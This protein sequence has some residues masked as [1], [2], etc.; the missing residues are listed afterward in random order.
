MAHRSYGV[1]RAT[2]M[3]F[4]RTCC[5]TSDQYWLD[6]DRSRGPPWS[7]SDFSLLGH[8]Q[9]VIDSLDRSGLC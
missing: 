4:G 5:G 2:I 8:F 3:L 7:P 1:E 9:S 6:R